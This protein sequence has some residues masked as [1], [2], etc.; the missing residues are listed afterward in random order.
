MMLS[1]RKNPL[2]SEMNHTGFPASKIARANVKFSARSFQQLAISLCRVS[3][4]W[5][6]IEAAYAANCETQ[7]SESS[8]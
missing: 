7:M 4:T 5:K 2:N 1:D 6:L 8:G 3:E